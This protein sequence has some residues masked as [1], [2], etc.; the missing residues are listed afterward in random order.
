MAAPPTAVSAVDGVDVQ[1]VAPEL[2]RQPVG[3]VARRPAAAVDAVHIDPA[4][5]VVEVFHVLDPPV[6]SVPLVPADAAALRG[7]GGD[8][9]G[10]CHEAVQHAGAV[11]PKGSW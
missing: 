9:R 8:A 10:G 7:D 11:G 2:E 1:R 6:G 3:G 5:G 4:N